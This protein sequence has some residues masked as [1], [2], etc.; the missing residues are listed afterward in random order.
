[1]A[2]LI[3]IQSKC[4][5]LQSVTDLVNNYVFIDSAYFDK[6]LLK[7]IFLQVDANARYSVNV[8]EGV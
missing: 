3:S 6:T 8:I 1:M 7:I 2:I 5:V 4:H